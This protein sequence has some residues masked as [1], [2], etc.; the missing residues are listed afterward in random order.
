MCVFDRDSR[1]D[2]FLLDGN[3]PT[4]NY[5]GA[6][7]D[8]WGG[9]PDPYVTMRTGSRTGMRS[10]SDSKTDTVTPMWMEHVVLN[11]TAQEILDYLHVEVIDEDVSGSDS[12]GAC[13]IT[14]VESSFDGMERVINCSRSD[15]YR[16]AGWRLRIRLDPVTGIGS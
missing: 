10:R 15:M 4:T 14:L 7:W 11:V 2:I 16:S 9:R 3:I 12:V 5:Y 1:W 8:A 13:L 6:A